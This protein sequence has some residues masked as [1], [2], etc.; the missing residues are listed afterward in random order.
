MATRDPPTPESLRPVSNKMQDRM[1]VLREVIQSKK[2][3]VHRTANEMKTRIDNRTMDVIKQLDA[4]WERANTRVTQKRDEM[5]KTITELNRHRS[6]METLFS[7]HNQHPSY[8]AQT[9]DS[10]CSMRQ[11][12]DV[13]IPFVSLSWRLSELRDC[14]DGM[15]V[16]ETKDVTLRNDLPLSLKWS[17][18]EK[19][20]EENQ[21]HNPR[22]VAIDVM[23]DR[24]Y[25]ACCDPSRVQIFSMNGGWIKC[26]KNE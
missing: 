20:E 7:K 9:D 8:L 13:D 25:V 4:V 21:I 24:V 16:C 6:D 15:C 10:I 3:L 17:C 22:G 11:E 12:L 5:D 1:N 26:L 2:A 14:I 19:G 18:G 23:N